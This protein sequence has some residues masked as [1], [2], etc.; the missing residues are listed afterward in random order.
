MLRILTFA[1][2]LAAAGPALAQSC[3]F[4]PLPPLPPPGCGAM[5]PVCVCD[6]PRCRW[7]FQCSPR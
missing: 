3:G 6:G 4:P 5:V 7:I 1:A 2:V